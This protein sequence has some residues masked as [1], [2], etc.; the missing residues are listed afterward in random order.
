MTTLEILCPEVSGKFGAPMGRPTCN[1]YTDRKGVTYEMTA[2]E[3]SPP[4][5]LARIPVNAG[6]YD[7]GGAYWGHGSGVRLFGFIGPLTDIRGFVWAK[8]REAAKAEVRK[9][10]PLAR[11]Y[12]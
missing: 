10:H 7:P 6:G 1:T 11:F 2:D 4:F 5:C 12:R 8:D 3:H 9:L